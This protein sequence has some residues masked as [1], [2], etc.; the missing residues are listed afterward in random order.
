VFVSWEAARGAELLGLAAEHEVPAEAIGTVGSAGGILEI[1]VRDRGTSFQ[2]Q[3]AELRQGYF[4][5]IPRRMR[6]DG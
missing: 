5:A 6:T 4:D 3:T 2:W 1:R